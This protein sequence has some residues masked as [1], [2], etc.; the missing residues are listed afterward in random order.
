MPVFPAVRLHHTHSA[1]PT[2][3]SCPGV[4]LQRRITSQLTD[5][6]IGFPGFVAGRTSGAFTQVAAEGLLLPGPPA[7]ER[8]GCAPTLPSGGPEWPNRPRRP[9]S[10]YRF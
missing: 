10:T 9:L 5:M 8:H 6:M 3:R 1:A 7:G 4:A 2:A